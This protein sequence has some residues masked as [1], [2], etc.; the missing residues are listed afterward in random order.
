LNTSKTF[1]IP[2]ALAAAAFAGAIGLLSAIPAFAQAVPSYAAASSDE[3]VHGTVA[4]VNGPYS[5]SVRDDRGF[6]DS[7]KLHRGTIIN[8][9]GLSL[10]P[11]QTVTILGHNE[12]AAF[13]AN[14]ID[15][16][17]QT[18][19]AVPRDPAYGYYGY[20]YPYGLGPSYRVGLRFGRGFGFGLRG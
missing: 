18:V 10:A 3:T 9:T 14:E 17:Y 11:G 7:V 8:P 19:E 1:N 13:S 4:A 12:G 15:T 5:I 20:P 16:P 6:V 2:R